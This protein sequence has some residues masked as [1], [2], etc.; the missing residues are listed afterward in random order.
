MQNNKI[1]DAEGVEIENI[2]WRWTPATKEYDEN[3]PHRYD[4]VAEG[5]VIVRV[6]EASSGIICYAKYRGIW[7]PNPFTS[8]PVIAKL[9]SELGM[10]IKIPECVR[11]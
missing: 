11:G 6:P 7:E 1:L 9:L 8:R 4:D 3:D 5:Y 2:I 10:G